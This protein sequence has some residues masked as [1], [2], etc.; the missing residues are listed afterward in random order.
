MLAKD[1]VVIFKSQLV[2]ILKYGLPVH[3][4]VSVFLLFS[5]Q[6]GPSNQRQLKEACL[7]V[8][9]LD[10]KVK[11]DLLAWFVK[12]QLSEYLVLFGEKEEVSMM[13]C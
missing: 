13:N 4:I 12:L 6:Y 1:I 10:S 2:Y 5:K 3:V 11:K 9:V 7:V 8:D